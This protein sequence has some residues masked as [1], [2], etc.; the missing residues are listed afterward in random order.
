[1]RKIIITFLKSLCLGLASYVAID[2]QNTS[3]CLWHL[4]SGVTRRFQISAFSQM[5][6]KPGSL[7]KPRES[8]YT[9]DGLSTPAEKEG[10][11]ALP[12]W[13]VLQYL[14]SLLATFI[15]LCFLTVS[16]KVRSEGPR[17]SLGVSQRVSRSVWRGCPPSPV[18]VGS[19]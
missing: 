10:L 6:H 3:C 12:L 15:C 16:Q 11:N 4:G 5:R 1:M 2:H 19:R 14:R 8:C 9:R 18:P 13:T 17:V 7:L